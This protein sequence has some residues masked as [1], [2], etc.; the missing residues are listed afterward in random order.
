M[1]VELVEIRPLL[2]IDLD[3]DEVLVHQGGDR[4]ILEA[5]VRHHVAPVAG[6]IADRQKDRLVVGARRGERGRVPRLPVDRIGA[7]LQQIGAGRFGEAVAHVGH[8][9]PAWSGSGRGCRRVRLVS[10]LCSIYMPSAPGKAA[11]PRRGAP[12]AAPSGIASGRPVRRPD[13]DHAPIRHDL[14]SGDGSGAGR[15]RH[16]PAVGAVRRRCLPAFDGTA[17]ARAAPGSAAPHARS[18]ERRGDRSGT[19]SVVSG[20]GELHRRGRARDARFTAV[21]R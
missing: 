5:L 19:G 9:S 8:R 1:L 17:A 13:D 3:V 15:A 6:R 7:V 10:A 11:R 16:R 18:E 20:T 2:A 12:T 14:R 21:G 4:G